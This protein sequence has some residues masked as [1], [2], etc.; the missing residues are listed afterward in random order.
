MTDNTSLLT[1][2][3][4]AQKLGIS[5]QTLR[6]WD[7]QGKL[8]AVRKSPSG[9]RYFDKQKV[10][11]FLVERKD[12]FALAYRWVFEKPKEPDASFYCPTALEFKTQ[13]IKFEKRVGELHDTRSYYPLIIASAGEIG[14]NSFDHNSGN[15]PDIT[16]MFFGFSIKKRE[17]V[18]ADRGRGILQTLKQV[19]P[20]L[21]NDTE[22]LYTAF[23]ETISGRAPEARGNGL[24]FVREAITKTPM[25]LF[26]QS[27]DAVLVLKEGDITLTIKN[28][29]TY[30]RGCLAKISF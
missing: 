9:N 19:R 23:T 18:L 5:I 10:E 21:K 29:D 28:S 12:L 2:S 20:G 24:K 26:F 22:A 14:N 16:G 1:I 25:Q 15:W 17:V 30:L 3:Q 6:R 27:G 7:K 4:T 8:T 11:E 13:L